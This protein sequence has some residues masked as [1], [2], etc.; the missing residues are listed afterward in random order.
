MFQDPH[1]GRAVRIDSCHICGS[2]FTSPT[3]LRH[4]YAS[5]P[6]LERPI[7]SSQTIKNRLLR[8]DSWGRPGLH[9]TEFKRLFVKCECGLVM[10]RRVFKEHECAITVIDLT[11]DNDDSMSESVLDLTD[12]T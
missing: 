6:V 11:S 10:T 1:G 7:K 8:L 4:A 9:E 12:D 2:N 3:D 5:V